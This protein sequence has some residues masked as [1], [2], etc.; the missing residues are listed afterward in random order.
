[1]EQILTWPS[2]PRLISLNQLPLSPLLSSP[3]L[4]LPPPRPLDLLHC[5][6]DITAEGPV[7]LGLP[8]A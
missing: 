7:M 5:P 3:L 1:M 2:A 4:L 6:V 8:P